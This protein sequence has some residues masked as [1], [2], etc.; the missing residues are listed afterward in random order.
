MKSHKPEPQHRRRP[1]DPVPV[2][3]VL[4]ELRIEKLVTGG[5][6]LARD[7]Q[8]ACFVPR[9][10]PGDLV[11]AA[12]VEERRGYRRAE[13]REL[14]EPGAD[15]C[16]APCPH[17]ETCG[18]CDLQ[19]LTIEAQRAAKL[20]IIAECFQRQGKL[21]VAGFMGPGRL[22]A[23]PWNGAPACACTRIP[24]ASTACTGAA[25]TRWCGWKPA[26]SWR[27]RLQRSSCPGCGSCRRSSRSW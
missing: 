13:L 19:H 7:D 10:A 18:G 21:D 5:D 22:A 2:E 27:R 4:V 15:R 23:R 9:T 16:A 3:P 17:Y 1:E 25:R 11:R 12:I 14:L 6:G 26:R 24:P 8:G 20:S